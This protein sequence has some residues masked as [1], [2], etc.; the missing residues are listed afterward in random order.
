MNEPTRQPIR[1]ITHENVDELMS[2]HAPKPEQVAHMEAMKPA[3]SALAHAIVEHCP[4]G[5]GQ[6]LA[7]RA[8]ADCRMQIN[9]AIIFEG[10]W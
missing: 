5:P 8:L 3:V 2:Y 4:S 1:P 10:A 6:T 9:S 7:L